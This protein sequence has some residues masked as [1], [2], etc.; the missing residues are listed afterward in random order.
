MSYDY[1]QHKM[2]IEEAL[3]MLMDFLR[4]ASQTRQENETLW[5]FLKLSVWLNLKATWKRD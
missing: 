1:G 3:S 4:V 2:S 5:L